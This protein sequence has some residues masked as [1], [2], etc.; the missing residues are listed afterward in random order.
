MLI[1]A[2]SNLSLAGE[3]TIDAMVTVT[4]FGSVEYSKVRQKIGFEET[5]W[6]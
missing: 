3:N 5:V 2:T 6:G 4:A 1:E